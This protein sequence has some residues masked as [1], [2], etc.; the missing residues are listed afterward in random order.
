MG[1]AVQ[2]A[3][4]IGLGFNFD[5]MRT[6]EADE[7]PSIRRLQARAAK[8]AI[9]RVQ[10]LYDADAASKE[11]DNIDD[12]EERDRRAKALRE[13]T[14]IEIKYLANRLTDLVPTSYSGEFDDS[15]RIDQFRDRRYK[16]TSSHE[17]TIDSLVDAVP[18]TGHSRKKSRDGQDKESKH[19]DPEEFDKE[20][21]EE[22]LK[23]LDNRDPDDCDDS[24]ILS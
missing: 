4:G 23:H 21:M 3:L 17:Y 6:L 11:L 13:K 14:A 12:P 19:R 15:E 1:V 8:S 18:F 7:K 22:Y 16:R 24:M 5:H 20:F 10:E 9:R 2:Q